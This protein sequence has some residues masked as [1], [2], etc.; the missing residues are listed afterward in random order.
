M[1]VGFIFY[2]VTVGFMFLLEKIGVL[3]LILS[4]LNLVSAVMQQIQLHANAAAV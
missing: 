1:I 4:K 3:L 2:V